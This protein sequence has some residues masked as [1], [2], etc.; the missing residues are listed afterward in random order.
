ME[1]NPEGKISRSFKIAEGRIQG[2]TFQLNL[3]EVTNLVERIKFRAI[4]LSD[5]Q[6]FVY[7]TFSEVF[8]ILLMIQAAQ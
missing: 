5:K 3:A 1:E 4:S 2:I 8:T 7:I 6:A